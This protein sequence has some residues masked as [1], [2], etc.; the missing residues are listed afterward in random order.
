MPAACNALCQVPKRLLACSDVVTNTQFYGHEDETDGETIPL[1]GLPENSIFAS[2]EVV[3]PLPYRDWVNPIWHRFLKS[4]R[5][6]LV[7]TGGLRFGR[8]KNW[9]EGVGPNIRIVGTRLPGSITIDDQE[10][11]VVERVVTHNKLSDP[12]EH[13]VRAMIDRTACECRILVSRPLEPTV[14]VES[15]RRWRF[16]AREIPSWVTIDEGENSLIGM[17]YRIARNEST[18]QVVMSPI[19]ERLAAIRAL[20]K[21]PVTFGHD[22]ALGMQHPLAKW[23]AG[24]NH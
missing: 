10:V 24:N 8:K 19:E 6:M 13:F 23:L 11:K 4:P 22:S 17:H 9:V 20:V 14:L 21:F 5:P 1:R 15:E 16:A 7:P 2:F 12:G 18:T 3:D